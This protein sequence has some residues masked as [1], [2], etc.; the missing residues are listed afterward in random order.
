MSF[1]NKGEIKK[2]NTNLLLKGE[3]SYEVVKKG[4]KNGKKKTQQS[5][6]LPYLPILY[7]AL[8]RKDAF[9][10]KCMSEK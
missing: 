1:S 3:K 7:K 9:T 4:K 2:K 5:L 8:F 10:K 6:N